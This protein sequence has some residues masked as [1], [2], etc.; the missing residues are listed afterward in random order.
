MA[1]GLSML[2]AGAWQTFGAPHELPHAMVNG[3]AED[4]QGDIWV[5][6][7]FSS[8][9]GAARFDGSRWTSILKR[10]GLAGDKVR[11]VF[12]DQAGAV[13]FGAEY[14]GAARLDG[15]RWSY[16]ATTSGLP[17]SEVKAMA[18]D[19]DGNMWFG[20]ERGVGRLAA[21]AWNPAQMP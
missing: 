13:W 1:G 21:G 11:S 14:D 17:G 15:A 8:R 4:A 7:G 10:D 6:T 3:I 19:K 5:G 16:L 2:E 18:Q 20:T 9:G 12:V